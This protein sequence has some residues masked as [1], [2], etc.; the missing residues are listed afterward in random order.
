MLLCDDNLTILIH[1]IK[2]INMIE[3]TINEYEWTYHAHV[4]DVYRTVK[5]VI[6][7]KMT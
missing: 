6:H 4:H 3:M 2:Y 5:F 7:I 1:Y